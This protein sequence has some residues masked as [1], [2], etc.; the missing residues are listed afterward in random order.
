MNPVNPYELNYPPIIKQQLRTIDQ[1]YHPLIRQ[2]IEDQLRY[3]P[4]T[5]TRNRK[6]LKRPVLSGA[7]WELRIGSN[8]C[9]RAFYR[10][11]HD[12]HA[13]ILLAIGE[14]AGNKLFIGGEEIQL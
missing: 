4:D 6:P 7:R 10:V 14:K 5:E 12:R 9:F 3:E 11:D 2:A 1:K 8:H 13:V